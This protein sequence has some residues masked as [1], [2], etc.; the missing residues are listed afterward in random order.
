MKFENVLACTRLG[1]GMR[2]IWLPVKI[3]EHLH[4]T[5]IDQTRPGVNYAKDWLDHSFLF[6]GLVWSEKEFY[7]GYD[8]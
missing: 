8:H 4:K 5:Q 3:V 2:N 1:I 6:P 7:F